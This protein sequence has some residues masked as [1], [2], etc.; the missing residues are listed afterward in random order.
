MSAPQ[1]AVLVTLIMY[2]FGYIVSLYAVSY[3]FS[4]G[5][6][7]QKWRAFSSNSIVFQAV[8]Y[9]TVFIPLVTWF[10][11]HLAV[12]SD[13]SQTIVWK[14]Y[15]SHVSVGAHIIWFLSLKPMVVGL[16]VGLISPETMGFSQRSKAVLAFMMH[17]TGSYAMVQIVKTVIV[18]TIE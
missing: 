14:D 6:M 18:F 10:S 15:L 13:V 7:P 16:I 2:T 9:A 17:N 4:S 1:I 8:I 5:L 11:F 3:W 12:E